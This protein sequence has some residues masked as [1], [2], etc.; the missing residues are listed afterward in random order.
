[1]RVEDG[2]AWITGMH[3]P[4]YGHGNIHN[5]EPVRD[6]RLLLH[7]REITELQEH[8]Q[9]KDNTIVPLSVYF[10]RGRAKLSLGVA[11]GKQNIDK[12]HA[13]AERDMKRQ[14]EREMKLRV[15]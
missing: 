11:R 3:I 9:R 10:I 13:I 12:R 2:Q 8:L 5:H 15:R 14:L 7:R 1:V 6:R 4:P